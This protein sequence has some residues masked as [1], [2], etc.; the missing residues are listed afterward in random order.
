M[1]SEERQQ[2]TDKVLSYVDSEFKLQD[3]IDK[4]HNSLTD[5]NKN[6][7]SNYKRWEV[8]SI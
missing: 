7:K 6:W 8:I 1:S 4:W 3:T 2:L 5:L